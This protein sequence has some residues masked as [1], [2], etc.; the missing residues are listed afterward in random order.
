MT[1]TGT[2]GTASRLALLTCI[3]CTT[4]LAASGSAQAGPQVT[5]LLHHPNDGVDPFGFDYA[6]GSDYFA[7]RYGPLVADKGRFDF[8][9]F[10]ADGVLPIEKLPDPDVPYAATLS[11]YDAAVAQRA[12]EATPVTL[13]LASSITPSNTSSLTSA[14]P[15]SDVVATARIV[16]I[17]PIDG[18]DLH[19]FLALTEDPVHFQPPPGLTNGVTEHRFTVRAIADLGRVDLGAPSNLTRTFTLDEDWDAQRLHV[20]AWLQ[21]G[22]GSPRFDAREVVQATT[23]PLG[24]SVTQDTKGVLVEMLSATWCDPCLYGDL[25]VEELAIARGAATPLAL[26]DGPRYFQAPSLPWLAVAAAALAAAATA[27]WGGGRR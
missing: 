23:A 12:N 4:L 10:I 27:W 22:A 15:G 26:D 8:P 20:A 14:A 6:F 1:G 17:E 7:I 25:A 11:A 24:E 13:H 9:Y 3:L 19:L 2:A 21:Q 18:E 5:V 16:P